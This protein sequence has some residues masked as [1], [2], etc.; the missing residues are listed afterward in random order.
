MPVSTE[1]LRFSVIRVPTS[2]KTGKRNKLKLRS[3]GIVVVVV[4]LLIWHS[5]YSGKPREFW[6][7]VEL[8]WFFSFFMVS[9]LYYKPEDSGMAVRESIVYKA[10]KV[11][12]LVEQCVLGSWSTAEFLWHIRIASLPLK[13]CFCC[14]FGK[15]A[16]FP[17]CLHTMQAAHSCQLIPT[18]CWYPSSWLP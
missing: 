8:S 9:K 12:K 4:S 17:G 7:M 6:R 16:A 10:V 14:C 18:K 3:L 5:H 1:S 13:L 11:S 15:S 2:K